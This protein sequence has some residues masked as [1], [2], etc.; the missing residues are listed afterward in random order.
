MQGRLGGPP[1]SKEKLDF[2]EGRL[3]SEL[4]HSNCQIYQIKNK[5]PEFW[6]ELCFWEKE[7]LSRIILVDLRGLCLLGRG[8]HLGG[9]GLWG[10][11]CLQGESLQR[12]LRTLSGGCRSVLEEQRE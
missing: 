6:D 11:P 5:K 7:E 3:L 8:G 1:K 4:F 10:S 9:P 12:P 2:C